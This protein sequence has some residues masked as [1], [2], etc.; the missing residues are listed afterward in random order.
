MEATQRA[1]F[2][3]ECWSEHYCLPLNP[4]KCET[5]F[6][7][8]N[9]H[10][11]HLQ[12]NLP[13]LNS[14]LYFNPTPTFLAVT[15]DRTLSF[16]KHVSSL[17]TKFFPHLKALR[18]ISALTWPLLRSPSLFCIKLFFGPFYICLTRIIFFLK[19]T[20][21]NWNASTERPVAPSPA[22]S[23]PPLSHF[24]SLRLFYPPSSHPDSFHSFI[25]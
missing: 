21:P 14:R 25:L 4:I 16:S 15:F 22:A 18:C 3:L 2:R 8:V 9:T 24:Y 10:Q 20:S 13:L 6:F 1:L 11:A 7:S 17:K 5:P 19:P 23:R 12:P